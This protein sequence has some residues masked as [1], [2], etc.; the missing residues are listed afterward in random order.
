M[1]LCLI[2]AKMGTLD[3]SLM[4]PADGAFSEGEKTLDFA[5]DD[6]GLLCQPDIQGKG[7][8]SIRRP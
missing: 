6:W 7:Q 8:Q 5:A 1:A 2:L 4:Q 3:W